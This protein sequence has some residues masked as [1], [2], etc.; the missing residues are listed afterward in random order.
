MKENNPDLTSGYY[1]VFIGGSSR[2]VFCDM[3]EDGGKQIVSYISQI[4]SPQ[5]SNIGGV[6][7]KKNHVHLLSLIRCGW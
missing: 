7:E 3:D 2:K 4:L 5:K 6:N 1:D